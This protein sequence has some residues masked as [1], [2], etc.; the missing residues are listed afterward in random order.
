MTQAIEALDHQ[1]CPTPEPRIGWVTTWNIP[2]GIASYSKYLVR[3]LS[4][5]KVTVLANNTQNLT[6]Q[7][8]PEVIRCWNADEKDN[9]HQLAHRII[10]AGITDIVIQFNFSF[11]NLNALSGFL[12]TMHG[13]QKRCYLFLHST[14]DV[15]PP[16][17]PK[18]LS[19]I[20]ASL[21]KTHRLV[22]HSVHDLNH[23][24]SIGCIENVMLFPH[25]VDISPHSLARTGATSFPAPNHPSTVQPTC[26]PEVDEKLIAAYG[27]LLPHKGI[28]ELIRAFE[29]LKKKARTSSCCF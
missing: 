13:Y 12:D 11:F 21:F 25:G 5:K 28:R 10:A 20:K 1:N 9:L 29:I 15:L 3:C 24:K 16:H 17:P 4:V 14:A 19:E 27:F 26:Q 22:V 23:L 8:G 2:C 7:D 6:E 18:S